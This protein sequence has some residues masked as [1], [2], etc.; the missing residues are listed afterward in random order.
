MAVM[1][2]PT[3]PP[4]RPAPGEPHPDSARLAD[5]LTSV[6]GLLMRRLRTQSARSLLSPTQRSALSRLDR[7]G[8]M[9]T[10]ALARAEH[11]RPQSMRATLGY[12]HEQGLV[13]RAPDPEDGRQSVVSVAERGRTVLAEVRAAKRTWLTH[14]LD[15]QL[16][17]EE[18]ALVAEAV[19][20]LGKV[21]EG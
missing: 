3:A 6:A 2:E 12:L 21:V 8:P 5:E 9:T 1:T 14:A 4:E 18:R 7:E 11:V 10:A 20:L 13:A 16:S 15:T 19:T 17:P